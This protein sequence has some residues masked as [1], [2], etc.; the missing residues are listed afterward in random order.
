M[1]RKTGRKRLG[2]MAPGEELVVAGYIGETGAAAIARDREEELLAWYT[3][4]YIKELQREDSKA[5][6]LSRGDWEALGATEYEMTG[7]GG[8]FTALWTLSGTYQR[9]VSVDLLSIPIR[10]KTIELCE[11]YELNPY[12][13]WSGCALLV[14]ENGGG[15][16][17][18]L[19]TMGICGAVIGCVLAGAAK[20]IRCHGETGCLE[21]PGLDEVYRILP[22]FQIEKGGEKDERENFSGD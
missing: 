7:E 22:G 6:G 15:L 13:L 21:R 5:A 18:K 12:R 8:I 1:I 9:G 3:K 17:R 19:E 20:E 2:R 10:Q 11:H 4:D 14:A 16:V